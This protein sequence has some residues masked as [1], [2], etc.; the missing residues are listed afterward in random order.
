MDGDGSGKGNVL[1][2]MWTEIQK[3][4]LLTS[5]KVTCEEEVNLTGY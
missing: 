5:R 1:L 2:V 3:V 4:S